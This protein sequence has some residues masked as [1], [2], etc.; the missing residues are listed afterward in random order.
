[1]LGIYKGL[2]RNE[3]ERIL[4]INK[5]FEVFDDRHHNAAFEFLYKNLSILDSKA[6]ALLSSNGIFLAVY[7]IYMTTANNTYAL[8][9]LV[10][11]M[12]LITSS[13]MCMNIIWVHW[14]TSEDFSELRKHAVI[15][16]KARY[17]RT[18]TY[19]IAW[20]FTMLA[21]IMLCIFIPFIELFETI[22]SQFSNDLELDIAPTTH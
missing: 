18:I 19:R 20:W 5:Y 1:M 11:I 6:T 15:L 4:H 8:I 3:E 16:L 17:R 2:P 7:S 9:V 13:I 22:F 12:C 21:I 14:S 10:P